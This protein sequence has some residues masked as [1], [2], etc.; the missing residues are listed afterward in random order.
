MAIG[1]GAA[2]ALAVEASRTRRALAA[3]PTS[4]AVAERA[5]G[6]ARAAVAARGARR[7]TAEARAA[8]AAVASRAAISARAAATTTVGLE[9]GCLELERA[10]EH[11]EGHRG[12][13]AA[14]GLTARACT[15]AA[16]A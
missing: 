13:A 16:A 9:Q 1:T 3:G 12:A 10:V 5:A 8:V 2:W 11:I 4:A 14:A 6:S 7:K 15:T